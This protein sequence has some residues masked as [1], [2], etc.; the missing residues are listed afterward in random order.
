VETRTSRIQTRN[1]TRFLHLDH[2]EG[3]GMAKTSNEKFRR[4][5]ESLRLQY[6][7]HTSTL[8]AVNSEAV[9]NPRQ[10]CDHH[11]KPVQGQ[12]KLYQSEQYD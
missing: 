1:V 10:H 12:Q 6:T 11:S 8:V 2:R 5:P 3:N 4:F 7:L 9:R